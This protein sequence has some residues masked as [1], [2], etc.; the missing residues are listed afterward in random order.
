MRKKIIEPHEFVK[1][2][3]H[4]NRSEALQMKK[5]FSIKLKVEWWNR[6]KKPHK[7]Y[8]YKNKGGNWNK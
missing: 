5:L 2:I 7:N 6:R 4:V 3:T 8:D 1:L